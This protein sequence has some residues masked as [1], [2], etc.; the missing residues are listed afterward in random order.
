[1]NINVSLTCLFSSRQTFF[2]NFFETPSDLFDEPI[3]ITVSLMLRLRLYFVTLQICCCE[4]FLP[5]V[6]TLGF[7]LD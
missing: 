1:M 5:V 6:F 4:V 2:L 3:F 7:A